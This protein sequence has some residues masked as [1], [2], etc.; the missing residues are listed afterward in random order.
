[1]IFKKK[2]EINLPFIKKLS[3]MN[4]DELDKLNKVCNIIILKKIENLFI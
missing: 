2:K 3:E 1:M 4:D